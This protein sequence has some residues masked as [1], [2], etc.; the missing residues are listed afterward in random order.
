MT[1]SQLPAAPVRPATGEQ[2]NDIEYARLGDLSLRMDAHIP[3]G[4][5]PFPAAIIVHGGGWFSGDSRHNVQPLFE[6]LADAGFAW[7]SINYRLTN[8]ISMFGQAVDDVEA[9]ANFIYDHA[10]GYRIDRDRMALIGESAGA[11]LASMAA[12]RGKLKANIRAVVAFYGPADLVM[13]AK[14]SKQ[15]PESVRKSVEG[16]PFEAMVLAGL[17]QLS[18]INHVSRNMPPFLLIHGTDDGMVPFEQSKNFCDRIHQAG[19]SCELYPVKG[20]DHGILW[21]DSVHL[22]AYKHHMVA[23]LEK[24][25]RPERTRLARVS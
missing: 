12:L 9:A 8:D 20:G 13:L 6:P 5:G 16:T 3:E 1:A 4:P 18:P 10:S 22:T 25:L 7:F 24:E 23:W 2:I 14:T 19:A 17:A 21:W 15:I 11:Q